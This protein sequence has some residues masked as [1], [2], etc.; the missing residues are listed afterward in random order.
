MKDSILTD[1]RLDS[2]NFI[3]TDIR[4]I[5]YSRYPDFLGHKNS[6]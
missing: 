2:C 5:E 6:V 3:E 1:A 4:N